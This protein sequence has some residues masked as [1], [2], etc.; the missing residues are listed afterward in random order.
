ME[1]CLAVTRL[2]AA[3]FRNLL[4]VMLLYPANV[5]AVVPRDSAWFSWYNGTT[6]VP[7]RQQAL[8][9]QDWLG[10]AEMDK[11]GKLIMEEVPGGH[12]QFDLTTLFEILDY[13]LS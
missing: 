7:L 13:Y 4:V 11:A 12:M 2:Q 6:L 9:Q 8:Y 3:K 5:L 10:L 1:I